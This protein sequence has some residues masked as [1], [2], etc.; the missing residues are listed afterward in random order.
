M[1]RDARDSAKM[2]KFSS[3]NDD[4]D[5]DADWTPTEYKFK[6]QACSKSFMT[7]MMLQES[8]YQM[9]NFSMSHSLFNDS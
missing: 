5:D 1:L 6:C 3:T 8:F 2:A 9:I 7:E 4:L